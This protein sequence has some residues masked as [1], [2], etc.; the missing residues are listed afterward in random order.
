MIK[1]ESN[2]K[3]KRD[4]KGNIYCPKHRL[5]V[6]SVCIK[7][8]CKNILNCIECSIQDNHVHFKNIN[9]STLL[10]KNLD[11]E[12]YNEEFYDEKQIIKLLKR[13]F[14]L[15]R[16]KINKGINIFEIKIIDQIK[17]YTKEPIII[18]SK[19]NFIKLDKNF[20][21]IIII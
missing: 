1:K 21:I 5:F 2:K 14:D 13:E 4:S 16:K 11:N 7:K 3:I 9:I 20:L 10:N 17:N 6:N 8:N 18:K 12:M 19:K 15:F